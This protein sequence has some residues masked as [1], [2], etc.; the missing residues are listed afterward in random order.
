MTKSGFT[1]AT[2]WMSRLSALLP[3]MIAVAEFAAPKSDVFGI[4]AKIAPP[5]S[6]GRGS[7]NNVRRRWLMS[8][9]KSIWRLA[10][11]GRGNGDG[12]PS[13]A[14]RGRVE[15]ERVGPFGAL[16]NPGAQQG[17]LFFGER[18]AFADG[19]HLRIFDRRAVK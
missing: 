15:R 17:D 6:L 8:L 10:A 13:G 19:R 7:R 1:P 5:A 11:A 18:L 9:T 3:G 12:V 16:I 4:Q 2:A 14:G